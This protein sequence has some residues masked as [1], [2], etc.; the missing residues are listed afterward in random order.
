MPIELAE[1]D[2][3]DRDFLLW[4]QKQAAELRRAAH[5]RVNLPIDF[6]NLAEEVESL[7]KSDRRAA[8]SHLAKIIE[9][10][11][12]LELSPA[13]RPRA[14]WKRSVRDA[15]MELHL[16]LEDSPSLE[17]DFSNLLERAYPLGADRAAAGLRK[18]AEADRLPRRCP[19]TVEQIRLGEWWPER[20][21][22]P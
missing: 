10:L 13:D 1:P 17:S 8:V 20:R 4:T 14:G 21:K 9:H 7:G 11:L 22:A 2:L 5:A 6:T 12:K 19:Y 15:R 18:H 3:Y 16:V